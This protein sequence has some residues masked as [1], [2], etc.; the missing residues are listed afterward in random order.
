MHVIILLSLFIC[1]IL[2][3]VSCSLLMSC[4]WTGAP[5]A[6][7]TLEP[8]R[9]LFFQ[10]ETVNLHCSVEGQNSHGWW[11][12]LQKLNPYHGHFQQH[13]AWV[14]KSAFEMNH[15][16]VSNSGIYRCLASNLKSNDVTLTVSG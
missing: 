6:V 15:L 16:T 7:L 4:V 8:K 3:H 2:S 11:Y 1:V 9:M 10:G 13:I 12:M 5:K 14:Q